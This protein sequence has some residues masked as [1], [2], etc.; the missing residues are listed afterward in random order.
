MNGDVKIT[1]AKD[2]VISKSDFINT[3]NG[4]FREN[5]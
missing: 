4:K 1:N 3:N 5:Y 2:L